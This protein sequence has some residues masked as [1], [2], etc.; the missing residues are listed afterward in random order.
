MKKVDP[1]SYLDFQ[2]LFKGIRPSVAEKAK[3]QLFVLNAA[4]YYRLCQKTEKELLMNS[5]I[6]P[7][8]LSRIKSH[9]AERGLRLNL[10]EKSLD[11]YVDEEYNAVH[12]ADEK[13]EIVEEPTEFEKRLNFEISE[14]LEK[15]FNDS[16]ESTEEFILENVEQPKDAHDTKDI[17]AKQEPKEQFNLRKELRVAYAHTCDYDPVRLMCNDWE[18][19]RHQVR[20]DMLREQPWYIKAFVPFKYRV[21]M[22]FEKAEV[23][24]DKY[25]KNAISRSMVYR[26]MHYDGTFKH[27]LN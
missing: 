9:L 1:F 4:T 25:Q 19:F 13:L 20:L 12:G 5:E 10:S 22:A 11:A 27:L 23:I 16:I 2:E 14:E 24:M 6:S 18:W 3:T 17:E 7:A 21:E 15:E 26:K 8:L